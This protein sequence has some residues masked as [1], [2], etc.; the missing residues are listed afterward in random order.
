[1]NRLV[2]GVAL[3]LAVAAGSLAQQGP[4][5]GK[6]KKVDADKGIVTITVGK[7]DQEFHVTKRTRLADEGGKDVADRLKDKRYKA[8]APVMFLARDEDGKRVLVGMKLVRTGGGG[9]PGERITKDTSHLKPLTELGTSKYHGYEGGLYPGGKNVRPAEH[10][11]AGLRLAGE[12][13]PRDADGKPRSDGKI[14]LLSVGMSNT[15][16]ISNGF[17]RHLKNATGINPRLVFVNG[18]QGSMTAQAIQDPDDKGRGTKYWD[19]VDRRLK[20]VGVT[21]EQVQAVW[22]KQADAGPDEG[23]PGYARKLQKE[24][25]KIVQ[26]LPKRFPNV[27]LVY[28]SSRTYGGYARTRL[29][30][31]PYAFESGFAVK[32][33]IQEQL[34]GDKVLNF[35]PARGEV[36]APWLSWGPYLWANGTAKSAEGFISEEGDFGGDGTHHSEAGVRKMGKRLLDFF[37]SDSTAKGWFLARE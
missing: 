23:F 33:L 14:V 1:M 5:Q 3:V 26:L 11:K 2:I 20:K 7:E 17:E 12:V 10:E 21:R 25:R 28:L 37:K 29:N 30:P 34:D 22:I 31:E 8:G 19:E 13:V 35:D 6:L 4:R 16:Q 36:K 9:L 24:L 27:K 18:A 32:W 15:S